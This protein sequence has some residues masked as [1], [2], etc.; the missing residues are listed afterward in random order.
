MS[1][2]NIYTLQIHVPQSSLA[3][4]M[5]LL[6]KDTTFSDVTFILEDGNHEIPAHKC[7]VAQRCE[8]FK[9]M[10]TSSMREGREGKIRI[11]DTKVEIF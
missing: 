7:I 2:N 8:V 11:M 4:D 9:N 10:L 1:F 3:T 6:M 5:R